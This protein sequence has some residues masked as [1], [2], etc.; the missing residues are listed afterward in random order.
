MT[1]DP[2][3]FLMG[4]GGKSAEFK[5]HDDQCWGTIVRYAMRQQTSFESGEPLVWDDGEPRMQ[6]V[7]T[8]QTDEQ[9]DDEDDGLRKLYVKGQMQQALAG[10]VLKAGATGVTEGGRVLVRYISDAEPK[11]QGMSGAK[12]YF[13]KYE[14]P[15]QAVPVDG[16]SYGEEPPEPDDSSLPF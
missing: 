16:D 5:K 6:M 8:V 10:A 15:T 1:Q 4:A 3:D 14:A 9:D 12:Q 2:N 11:R 13:A 7:L